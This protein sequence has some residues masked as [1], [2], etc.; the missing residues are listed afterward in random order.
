MHDISRLRFHGAN[1]TP[2]QP[3]I[4]ISYGLGTKTYYSYDGVGYGTANANRTD[5]LYGT[6]EL[7]YSA[8][9]SRYSNGVCYSS[10]GKYFTAVTS[11]NATYIQAVDYS[12][13]LKLWA[14][15]G[16][17]FLYGI[18]YA[19]SS[20]AISWTYSS[21]VAPIQSDGGE[22]V[23]NIKWVGS[24]SKFVGVA[25]GR[26]ASYSSNGTS[27]TNVT[28]GGM[29][30]SQTGWNSL[31]TSPVLGKTLAF[32]IPQPGDQYITYAKYISTSDG[33]T[34]TTN[35]VPA[36]GSNYGLDGAAWSTPL[37]KF[38]AIGHYFN[39]TTNLWVPYTAHSSDG[40][41]WTTYSTSFSSSYGRTS[42][43]IKWSDEY[44]RFILATTDGIYYSSTGSS[45]TASMTFTPIT[46][47]CP[48]I[49]IL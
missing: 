34:W 17:K 6:L 36:F 14:G 48:S 4:L 23:C 3:K 43:D 45:W 22:I 25:Y 47:V 18:Q 8:S 1:Y 37:N 41:S 2:L 27:W 7:R 38:V 26:T 32:A 15:I 13:T 33:V 11:S 28:I 20:D 49:I 30:Y 29:T 42:N 16:N 5:A 40:S 10:D 24:Y 31:C 39:Y 46:L 44:S 12:P 19:Y 9:Q 21:L 35:N